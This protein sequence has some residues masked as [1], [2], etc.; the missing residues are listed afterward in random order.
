MPNA[1]SE[2]PEV[3]GG[4][5][6]TRW[7]FVI[8]ATIIAIVCVLRQPLGIANVR[9]AHPMAMFTYSLLGVIFLNILVFLVT[10]LGAFRLAHNVSAS[11]ETDEQKEREVEEILV[12]AMQGQLP[13]PP[14]VC[15]IIRYPLACLFGSMFGA[16]VGW[17]LATIIGLL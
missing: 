12:P 6:G 5:R 10:L 14:M 2:A 3:D 7:A 9:H 8:A 17:P 4:S 15:R 1:M 13:P 11:T 16:L